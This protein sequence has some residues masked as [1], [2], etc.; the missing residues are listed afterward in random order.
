MTELLAILANLGAGAILAAMAL[1]LLARITAPRFIHDPASSHRAY[2]CVLVLASAL[3]FVPWLRP[4]P[5]GAP[6]SAMAVGETARG[7]RLPGSSAGFSALGYDV[8]C[9]LGGVWSVAFV[10]AAALVVVSLLQL[11]GILLRAR[12][13]E[14]FA[15]QA[16]LRCSSGARKVRRLLVSDEASVPFAAVPWAPVVV[17]PSTFCERF[18]A[19]ALAL[20]I[21]HEVAH[22]ERG[23][24]WTSALV[25]ILCLMFPFN[26]V[27]ARLADEIAFAR[28]ASVDALVSARD[29]HR[30]ASLLIDVAA[31]AR[32]DELPRPVSLDATALRRRIE[33][34]TDS[35]RKRRLSLFPPALAAASFAFAALGAPSVFASAA[36]AT[37]VHAETRDF[38]TYR[39]V[40]ASSYQ[41]CAD[42]SA[43]D[44]CATPDFEEGRCTLNS[45][46]GS[47]FCAAPPPSAG[48]PG[49][50]TRHV[51]G[52]G[53]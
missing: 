41:A 44:A 17:L 28:E 43:D 22:V 39:A 12:P 11:T 21:E 51:F 14:A 23:D 35:S 34:L 29:P 9:L 42:K 31:S 1:L 48:T 38:A 33:M 25:R 30:Y 52:G 10:F 13:A 2:L 50:E 8:L 49:T 32:F 18:D 20:A 27:A 45:E 4:L 3:V 40:P 15:D 19:D 53:R 46:D 26:P 16:L 7:A 5:R 24:L 6:A 37:S 36:Q 47:L